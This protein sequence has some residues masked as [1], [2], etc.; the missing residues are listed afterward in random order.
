MNAE[1]NGIE[2]NGLYRL[3][4]NVGS[5]FELKVAVVLPG[6]FAG[7]LAGM[8][9]CDQT[10]LFCNSLDLERI[11][12]EE[13]LS[14]SQ[15][16]SDKHICS[17]FMSNLFADFSVIMWPRSTHSNC[18]IAS[19]RSDYL[20]VKRWPCSI[21]TSDI[22]SSSST[23]RTTN[24]GPTIPGKI[25]Q[26]VSEPLVAIP[27][28]RIRSHPWERREALLVIEESLVPHI[29][30]AEGKTMINIGDDHKVKRKTVKRGVP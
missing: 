6:Q 28:K 5:L 2:T 25:Q 24:I 22:K 23:R 4:L 9:I 19:L 16:A 29:V 13:F 27:V 12:C 11:G 7:I 17:D 30:L 14:A 20:T 21:S 15:Q 18:V 1:M 3:N 26:L 10:S 8:Y